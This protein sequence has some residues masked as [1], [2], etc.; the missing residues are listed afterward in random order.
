MITKS[1][2]GRKFRKAE[3]EDIVVDGIVWH[4]GSPGKIMSFTTVPARPHLTTIRVWMECG[5]ELTDNI[6]TFKVDDTGQEPVIGDWVQCLGHS[7]CWWYKQ[8]GRISEILP[9]WLRPQYGVL[10]TTGLEVIIDDYRFLRN[11]E[12]ERI[13]EKMEMEGNLTVNKLS[14]GMRVRDKDHNGRTGT[15]VGIREK[16]VMIRLDTGIYAAVKVHSW[17]RVY[18]IEKAEDSVD[19][20]PIPDLDLCIDRFYPKSHGT[21]EKVYFDLTGE[22]QVAGEIAKMLKEMHSLYKEKVTPQSPLTNGHPIVVYLDDSNL[23]VEQYWVR[24]RDKIN[25]NSRQTYISVE[26]HSMGR[27]KWFYITVHL[28]QDLRKPSLQ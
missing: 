20:T 23:M 27:E 28:K 17:G 19:G 6:S 24:V 3:P 18:G 25:A 26:M 12:I 8:V 13:E 11:D 7:D 4:E 15:L 22:A 5:L 2:T 10:L 14:C 16:E 1:D 21:S 9:G